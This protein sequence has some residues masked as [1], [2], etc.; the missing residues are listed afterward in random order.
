VKSLIEF[1]SSA[2]SVGD[3]DH[4]DIR[5]SPESATGAALAP[6]L[7]AVLAVGVVVAA[8]VLP[9]ALMTIANSAMTASSDLRFLI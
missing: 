2:S 9:H 1:V 6:E 4:P 8:G 5:T 7:A 3:D